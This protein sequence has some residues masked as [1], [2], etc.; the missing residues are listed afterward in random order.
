MDP[1]SQI[2][3]NNNL[4]A[5]VTPITSMGATTRTPNILP[6]PP[7]TAARTNPGNHG[8]SPSSVSAGRA[9]Y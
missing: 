3:T 8:A 1:K 7:A 6:A 4:Q 2:A 5:P 9:R